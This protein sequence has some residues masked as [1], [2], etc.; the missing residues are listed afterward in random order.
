MAISQKAV[1]F[2]GRAVEKGRPIPG[3][4]LTNSPDQPYAWERPPEFTEPRQAMYEVFDVLTEPE[5]TA[6]IL[7]SLNRGVGVIDIASI[8]LYGGFIEGKWNADLMMLL[9]E[10]TMYMVMALAEKAEI[11]Y[12]LEA[13]DDEQSPVMSGDK[14]IEKVSQAVTSLEDI[15]KQSVGNVSEQVV[16]PEVREMV[17][18]I[19][20]QPSLLARVEK[21]SQPRESLLAKGEE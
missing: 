8:T 16:P 11:P 19:E 5:T 6:N 4:S 7:I 18:E 2:L 10:P 17:E 12:Q 1:D 13:G 9:M 21:E 3:Q 15:R 14:Q 20:I